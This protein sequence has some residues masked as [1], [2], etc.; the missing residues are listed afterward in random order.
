MSPVMTELK[1]HKR[2]V[3]TTNSSTS[4]LFIYFS[5]NSLKVYLGY[6]F[7]YNPFFQSETSSDILE[8]NL[9]NTRI[10]YGNVS[11]ETETHFISKPVFIV[12]SRRKS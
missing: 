1:W 3:G 12:R 4:W 8:I 10:L 7:D 9:E 5:H 6:A 11:Q 2:N